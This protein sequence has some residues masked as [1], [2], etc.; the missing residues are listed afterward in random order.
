MFKTFIVKLLTAS[1][2]I[3]SENVAA[4][5]IRPQDLETKLHQRNDLGYKADV[6]AQVS[7]Y[8]RNR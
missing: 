5:T 7:S 3:C 4:I 1:I 2:L 6:L 8:P